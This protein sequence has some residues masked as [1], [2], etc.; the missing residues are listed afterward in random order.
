ML[1]RRV[2]DRLGLQCCLH[3]LSSFEVRRGTNDPT[4]QH[5][6]VVNYLGTRVFGSLGGWC[7]P[8][9]VSLLGGTGQLERYRRLVGQIYLMFIENSKSM[10]PERATKKCL[11]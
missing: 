7:V 1:H 8:L 4:S 6:D 10:M 9:M 3:E 11:Y 5:P 2:Q